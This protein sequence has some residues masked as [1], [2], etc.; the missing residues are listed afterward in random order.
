FK[1]AR[2]SQKQ[3]AGKYT[4]KK[5]GNEKINGYDCVHAVVT[6]TAH[7]GDDTDVWTNKSIADWSALL[8]VMAHGGQTND[9]MMQALKEVG[10]D[11]FIVK[12]VHKDPR[13]QQAM[14]MEL[15][16]I[17]KKAP[18]DSIFQ[19]P[20]D[21]KKAEGGFGMSPETQKKLQEQMQRMTPEQREKLMKAMKGRPAEPAPAPEAQPK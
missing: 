3:A 18:P 6:N 16:K 12:L 8:K 17:E 20:A 9:S 7:G 15:D 10:A 14:V 21:Y 19:I 11:G 2:E 1:K 13:S 5:V 4:A